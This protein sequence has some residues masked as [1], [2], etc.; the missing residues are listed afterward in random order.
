MFLSR[1]ST[2]LLRLPALPAHLI[3]L[4]SLFQLALLVLALLEASVSFLSS[5]FGDRSIYFIV[6]LLIGL[7]GIFGG[8]AYVSCYHWLGI[9]EFGE[10]EAA[11]SREI[12]VAKREFRVSAVGFA[13]TCG[14]V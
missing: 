10:E 7:E 11:E 2:S 9:E 3:P 8:T 5:L 6:W 13:D 1:S 14:C 12:K 4:P